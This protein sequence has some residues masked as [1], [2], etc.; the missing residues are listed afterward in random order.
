MSSIFNSLKYINLYRNGHVTS[1]PDPNNSS[2]WGLMDNLI[3]SYDS[4]NKL[5][6]V[7]D[8]GNSTYGFKDGANTSTEYTYD[9]NGNMTSDANKGITGITYNHLNLPKL[10]TI[11]G[12]NIT[13]TYDAAGTK[14]RKVVSG[15][16]T[17][18]AGDFIYNNNNLQF[19][20]HAEGYF[21]VT[22]TNGNI[23]GNYIYQ[24]K[25]QVG[26]IRLSYSDT[27]NNGSVSASAEIIEESNY[28][29][30][31]LKHKGYNSVVSSNGNS[32]A[33]KYGFQEQQLEDGLGLNW[34]SFKWRNHDPA[35]GRF[36]TI[37]PLTEVY[38]HWAPYV[39]SG[40]RII[41]SRELEGLEP[42]SIHRT[43]ED[44]AKNFGI[45]YNGISIREGKEYGSTI[46]SV[47]TSSG[48]RYAYSAPN[49]GTVSSV[50]F[51]KNPKGTTRV[52]FIHTHGE[53]LSRYDNNNFS[54]VQGP[55]GTKNLKSVLYGDIGAANVYG[56]SSYISTPN[57]TLQKYDPSTG[58]I[59]TLTSFLP[60]DPKDPDRLNNISPWTPPTPQIKPLPTVKPG[61]VQPVAPEPHKPDLIKPTPPKPKPLPIIIPPKPIKN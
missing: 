48:I 27:N 46:Y 37:D 42:A 50:K 23:S 18:Y 26:S 14:L 51:S 38:H 25:D 24:Y 16:T 30:F 28:Y 41:D 17:D 9:N 33:Q 55:G 8:S 7:T 32:S 53:Y 57:G 49:Q 31:G 15:V 36:M 6:K 5:T 10:V 12:Q 22:S 54:G 21:N 47:A 35:I 19:L 1:N 13:Y 59:G 2:H 44:A 29:P 43:P 20:N 3:Y 61:T 60:S 40:N 39:F 52:A 4:G 11:N 58:K 45:Y 34:S 56:I